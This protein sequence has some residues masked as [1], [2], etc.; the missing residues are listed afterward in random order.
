[1]IGNY[2]QIRILLFMLQYVKIVCIW[3][4]VFIYENYKRV[5]LSFRP[6]SV[7]LSNNHLEMNN[8]MVV[9]CTI[10]FVSM[11]KQLSFFLFVWFIVSF[12]KQQNWVRWMCFFVRPFS[13]LA[14]LNY[15]KHSFTIFIFRNKTRNVKT[16]LEINFV[17]L[18]HNKTVNSEQ[19][20][21]RII[22]IWFS[23]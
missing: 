5:F 9:V 19:Q 15:M 22:F 16:Y 13:L 20:S 17:P 23:F 8:Y 7:K 1:M 2:V 6:I 14:H 3:W 10:C 4:C 21:Q 12:L 18:K 11:L